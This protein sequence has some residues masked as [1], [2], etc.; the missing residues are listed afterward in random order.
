VHDAQGDK[1]RTLM[2][3][4]AGTISPASLSFTRRGTVLVTPAARV[5]PARR[6]CDTARRRP[7]LTRRFGSRVAVSISLE[8]RRGETFAPSAP[9]AQATTTL[10]MLAGLIA[11][12]IGVVE[13]D[14]HP[15]T[16]EAAPS[17][18]DTSYRRRGWTV[19]ARENRWSTRC[20]AGRRPPP[21][22]PRWIGSGSDRAA[23]PAA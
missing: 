21:W 4:A 23:D 13:I 1:S 3:R 17:G 10:R 12:S 22:M 15:A 5:R 20:T 8:L 18:G 9:T 14:G 7:G 11:P 6:A 19:S 16:P 2:F